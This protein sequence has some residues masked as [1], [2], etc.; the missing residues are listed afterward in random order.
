[1]KDL[2]SKYIFHLKFK[3][4]DLQLTVLQEGRI[5]ECGKVGILGIP[6]CVAVPS[7]TAVN[8]KPKTVRPK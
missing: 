2:F 6:T 4:F 1:M 5:P 8:S 7:C 3:E